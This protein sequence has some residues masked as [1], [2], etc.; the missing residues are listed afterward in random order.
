MTK[1]EL[2]KKISTQTGIERS[3]VR[4]VVEAF[5]RTVSTTMSDG[6]SVHLR[7]FG[8]FVNKKRARK[9]GRNISRNTAIEIEAHYRPAFRPAKQLSEEVRKNLKVS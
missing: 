2:I 3:D 5:C 7:G 4:E 1:A 8:S 9:V 6:E